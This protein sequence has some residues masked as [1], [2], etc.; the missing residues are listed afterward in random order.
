M[1]RL[2]Y[3]IWIDRRVGGIHLVLVAQPRNQLKDTHKDKRNKIS[4]SIR[5]INSFQWTKI[6]SRAL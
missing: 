4:T 5:V 3:S 6:P 1:I 2:S